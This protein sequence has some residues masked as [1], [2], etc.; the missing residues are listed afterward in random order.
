MKRVTGENSEHCLKKR[1]GTG[2]T[3]TSKLKMTSAD[4]PRAQWV[5]MLVYVEVGGERFRLS[6]RVACMCVLLATAQ[7]YR[8][9][10]GFQG[11]HTALFPVEG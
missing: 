1:P 10:R 11:Y 3:V 4:P 8:S 2:E 9:A 6:V 5:H 7:S